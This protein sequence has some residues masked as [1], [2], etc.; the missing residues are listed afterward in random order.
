MAMYAQSR[1]RQIG[2]PEGSS[3]CGHGLPEPTLQLRRL[4]APSSVESHRPDPAP[5][6]PP[7]APCGHTAFPPRAA[8]APRTGE[9][10]PAARRATRL[11]GP[12]AASGVDACSGTGSRKVGESSPEDGRRAGW[13]TSGGE[14]GSG[15]RRAGPLPVAVASPV[16]VSSGT[17]PTIP[18]CAHLLACCPVS[19]SPR[20]PGSPWSSRC[21]LG[22]GS[23]LAPRWVTFVTN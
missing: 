1:S 4:R 22:C 5:A 18:T 7:F 11:A 9:P 8:V 2:A 20:R 15:A 6:A 19:C 17:R 3:S 12:A 16:V 13:L 21:G 23:S 14:R 10:L